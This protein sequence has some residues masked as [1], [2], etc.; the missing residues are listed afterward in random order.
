MKRF[1]W[2]KKYLYWGMTAFLVIAS[3]IVFYMLV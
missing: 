3:C 2:D 1:R